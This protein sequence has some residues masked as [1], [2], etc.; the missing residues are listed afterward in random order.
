MDDFKPVIMDH[1]SLIGD[2]KLSDETLDSYRSMADRLR[3]LARRN[4]KVLLRKQ[5]IERICQN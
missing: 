3:K 2:G 4:M 5:K 1:I